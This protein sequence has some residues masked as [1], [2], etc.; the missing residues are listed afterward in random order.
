MTNLATSGNDHFSQ[1]F[2]F[3]CERQN[4][5]FWIITR[6]FVD[7]SVKLQDV[8]TFNCLPACWNQPP[9]W[10]TFALVPKSGAFCS[11]CFKGFKF[12]EEV[13]TNNVSYFHCVNIVQQSEGNKILLFCQFKKEETAS[14]W[15]T[16]RNDHFHPLYASQDAENN[17]KPQG[18]FFTQDTEVSE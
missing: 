1:R 6:A 12:S 10:L 2:F 11:V 13:Q 16:A 15:E 9:H 17:F 8:N 18:F 3:K 4:W 7:F 14:T 5:M